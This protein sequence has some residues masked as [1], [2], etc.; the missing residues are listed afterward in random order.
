MSNTTNIHFYILWLNKCE[1]FLFLFLA[2]LSSTRLCRV[3]DFCFQISQ[4]FNYTFDFMCYEMNFCNACVL[5]YTMFVGFLLSLLLHSVLFEFLQ[6]ISYYSPISR[7]HILKMD[8]NG[9]VVGCLFFV[10]SSFSFI[11][12]ISRFII[13]YHV[14][15]G[16]IFF[17]LSLRLLLHLVLSLLPFFFFFFASLSR[18]M[19]F[20]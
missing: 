20:V 9:V 16:S 13:V 2:L 5:F 19:L 14:S 8:G 3:F 18:R 1:S 17:S 12:H 11:V 7:I 6:M 4:F 15:V 10:P